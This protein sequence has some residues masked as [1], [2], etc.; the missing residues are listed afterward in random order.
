MCHSTENTVLCRIA[1]FAVA[2]V[3]SREILVGS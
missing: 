3:V 1:G 2:V